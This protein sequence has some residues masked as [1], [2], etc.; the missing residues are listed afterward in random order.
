MNLWITY[1]SN[2]PSPTT[3]ENTPGRESNPIIRDKQEDCHDNPLALLP[4]EKGWTGTDLYLYQG[5]WCPSMHIQGVMSF[6]QHFK[7]QDTD[8]ILATMP[9]SGTTWLK[10]LTFAIANRHRYTKT[11]SQHPLLTSNPHDLIPFH[12]INHSANKDGH[13]DGRIQSLS[14]FQSGIFSTH[15]PYHSY[16]LPDS[17]KTSNCRIVHLCRNPYDSFVSAWHFFSKPRPE[18]LEPLS[19]NHAFDMYC[20]GVIGFGPF[21]DNVLG[22]WKESLKTPQKVLFLMY[23]DLK[24]DI[25]FQMKRLAEF[26][27]VPFSLEEESEGVIEEISRLCN[28]NN[29]R[30]LE[31]NKTGKSIRHFENKTFFR[32]GEV[33]DWI[34]HFTPEM[35][36]RLNKVIEEKLGGSGLA[37]K[38]SL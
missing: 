6:Q 3:M 35:V 23:E 12:K 10:A 31:V 11:L 8:L 34:N 29:M 16:S 18:S 17:I 5:F 37:F 19:C 7:A 27:S 13:Q 9:K 4:K 22:Y 25:I 38:T 28:F 24:E 36:E 32:R 1:N 2:I 14:N 26:M 20:R 21:W 33:G 30:E 15:M